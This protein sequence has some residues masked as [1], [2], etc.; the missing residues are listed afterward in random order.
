MMATVLMEA[1]RIVHQIATGLHAQTTVD[2]ALH[3]VEDAHHLRTLRTHMPLQT[4][5]AR[6]VPVCSILIFI[7]VLAC[8]PWSLLVA[9]VLGYHFN[10]SSRSITVVHNP[11]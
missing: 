7:S 11:C 3:P 10:V 1:R 6:E 9:Q 5:A 2:T 8:W 4:D